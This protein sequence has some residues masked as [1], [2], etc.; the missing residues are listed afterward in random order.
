MMMLPLNEVWKGREEEKSC[1]I[2][3]FYLVLV[4]NFTSDLIDGNGKFI[5]VGC[6]E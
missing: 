3:F 6:E 5:P 1:L 4:L 2:S